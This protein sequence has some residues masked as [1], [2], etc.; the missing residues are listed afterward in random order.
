M[1]KLDRI[2]DAV[3]N[4]PWAIQPESMELIAAVIE[5]TLSDTEHVSALAKQ[6]FDNKRVPLQMMSGLPVIDVRGV[7]SRRMNLFSQISGGTSIEV[8][9]DQFTEALASDAP[10]IIFNIDSPGGGVQGVPEFATRVSE[11]A[12]NSD[13]T[14]VSYAELAASAAY[15]IGSQANDFYVSE[16]GTVGSI[17]IIAQLRDTSRAEK[18]A[19]V[20]SMTIRSSEMKAPGMGGGGFTEKQMQSVKARV[21]EMTDMFKAAVLRGRPSLDLETI[22]PGEIWIGQKAVDQGF[23]DGIST[24][25]KVISKYAPK[26]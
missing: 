5:S 1:R 23:V 20:D 8:L 13:K 9:D 11:A 18:N 10:A 16:A 22:D 25:D 7:I 17:G 19:G 15:W 3:F 6:N 24:L 14:I 21:M 12:R 2:I 26:S 4:Q